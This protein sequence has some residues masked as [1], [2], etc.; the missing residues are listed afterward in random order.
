MQMQADVGSLTQASTTSLLKKYNQF[1][2]YRVYCPSP[3]GYLLHGIV[4]VL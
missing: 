4:F 1:R 2:N 3:S